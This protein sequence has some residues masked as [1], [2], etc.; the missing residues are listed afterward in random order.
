M[1]YQIAVF[2]HVLSAIVWLG[3]ALFLAMVMV[4]VVRSISETPSQSAQ[5][6]GVVARRFRSVAWVA[7]VLLVVTGLYIATDQW[8]VDLNSFVTRTDWFN[9]MLQMKVG[10]VGIVII[11]SLIHDFFLGPRINARLEALREAQSRPSESLQKQR[12]GL[13]MLARVNV[14]LVLIIVALAITMTRGTPF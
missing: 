11:L 1:M 10:L 13:I 5:L 12:R 8:S 3:G 14:L 2:I 6:L 9:K 4:P 7:I